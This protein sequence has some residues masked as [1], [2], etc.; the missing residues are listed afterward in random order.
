MP[1]PENLLSEIQLLIF[2]LD[3]T[4]VDSQL[5]LASSVNAMRAATGLASLEHSV[6][7]SYVGQGVQHLVRR[8]LGDG[9]T[10]AEVERGLATFLDYYREHML[11]HTE[12]YSGVREALEDFRGRTLAVLTNKPLR[13]SREM[14]KGLGIAPHF[15]FI[16]GGDSFEQKKPDPVGVHHLLRVTRVAAEHAIMTGDSDTDV[17]TGRNAGVW[18]CGVTYG[19][20]AHTLKATPPDMLVSDLRDLARL[21]DGSNRQTVANRHQQRVR[22]LERSRG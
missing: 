10:D 2:D 20:G 7:A 3:G 9:A 15:A 13:F 5:D 19:F 22:C 12:T 18:T 4:L 16:Y 21:L 17:L 14:L 6:I 8:A 1:I 11:D